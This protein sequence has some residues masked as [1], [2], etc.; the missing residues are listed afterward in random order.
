MQRTM[1][2]PVIPK[3]MTGSLPGPDSSSQK[4][5]A[6][7]TDVKG[8]AG[9]FNRL[10]ERSREV[11]LHLA[12]PGTSCDRPAFQFLDLLCDRPCR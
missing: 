9:M 5:R 6:E 8:S 12:F 7:K 4:L 10:I 1:I 2:I 3:C 11:D